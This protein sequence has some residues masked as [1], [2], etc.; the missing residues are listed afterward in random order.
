MTGNYWLFFDGKLLDIPAHFKSVPVDEQRSARK[1]LISGEAAFELFRCGRT[2][3]EEVAAAVLK[4]IGRK[5][6][7][8]LTPGVC[9]I[10]LFSDHL[11]DSS[12]YPKDSSETDQKLSSAFWFWEN[13]QKNN[14]GIGKISKKSFKKSNK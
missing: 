10:K 11:K 3:V 13:F 12:G 4:K 14:S 1:S 5:S 9:T 8:A 6:V 7:I 2:T